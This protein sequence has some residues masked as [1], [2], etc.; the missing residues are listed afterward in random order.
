MPF[1][2]SIT[3]NALPD[4]VWAA[5]ENPQKMQEWYDKLLEAKHLSGPSVGPGATY[6]VRYMLGE[7]EQEAT[8]TI[9]RFEQPTHLSYEMKVVH[10][11]KETLSAEHYELKADGMKTK[12]TQRIEPIKG[13]PR[14]LVLLLRALI[15]IT[16]G[17]KRSY[18]HQL[19]Q[20]IESH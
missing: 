9:R 16:G 3:I 7:R 17:N 14:F 18:L 5:I 4:V 1:H 20:K 2:Y 6:S 10:N 11:G 12:L 8:Y 13:M 19:K 15:L